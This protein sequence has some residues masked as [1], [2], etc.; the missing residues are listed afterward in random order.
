MPDL[1]WLE[2]LGDLQLPD[3]SKW[4]Q[5]LNPFAI[6]TPQTNLQTEQPPVTTAL[7]LAVDSNIQLIVDGRLLATIVKPFLYQDLIRY[8]TSAASTI[9]RSVVG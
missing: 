4:F 2:K 1:S 8:M 6:P 5:N 9:N 7:N 3:I